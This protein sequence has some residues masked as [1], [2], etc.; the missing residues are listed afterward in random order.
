M[1]IELQLHIP[2]AIYILIFHSLSATCFVEKN[3]SDRNGNGPVEM[4]IGCPFSLEKSGIGIIQEKDE[5]SQAV[6]SVKYLCLD[7][8]HNRE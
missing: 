8:D 7:L 2:V 6:E 1:G 3:L 5:V 4:C